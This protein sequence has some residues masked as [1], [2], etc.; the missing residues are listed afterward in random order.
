MD[1]RVGLISPKVSVKSFCK[2]KFPHKS[3][4]SFFIIVMVT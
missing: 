1:A 2:S 3:V 4:K